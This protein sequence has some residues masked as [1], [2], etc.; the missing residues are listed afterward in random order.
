MNRHLSAGASVL[1][2]TLLIACGDSPRRDNAS[3]DR[4]LLTAVFP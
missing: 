4:F 1:A 2:L 3:S